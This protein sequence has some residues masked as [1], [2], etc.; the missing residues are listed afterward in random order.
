MC[1]IFIV[2]T[3]YYGCGDIVEEET[4]KECDDVGKPG[5]RSTKSLAGSASKF[6]K[7]G[8]PDCKRP[9]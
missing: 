5:H 2:R 1:E 7:C 4:T 3:C 6:T 8:K 9:D